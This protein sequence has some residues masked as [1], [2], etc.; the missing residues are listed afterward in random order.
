MRL[1]CWLERSQP[2]GQGWEMVK[3]LVLVVALGLVLVLGLV[4]PCGAGSC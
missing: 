2:P 3:G 1:V 4:W